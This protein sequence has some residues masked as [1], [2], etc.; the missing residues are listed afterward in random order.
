I[1]VCL[2]Y[3]FLTEYGGLERVMANHANMLKE[4][5]FDIEILTCH[6]DKDV[7]KKMGFE[8]LKV[9]NISSIK[10]PSEFLSLA[11]CFLGFNKI[12]NVKADIFLSYSFPSNFL[13][14]K[15]IAKKVN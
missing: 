11:L 12:K 7:L 15:K 13:I 4:Q 8:G 10:T 14:R 6:Y 3:D 5:G 9:T 1:K 2:I